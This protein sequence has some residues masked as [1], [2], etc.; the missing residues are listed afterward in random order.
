MWSAGRTSG[1]SRP[2]KLRLPVRGPSRQPVIDLCLRLFL[3]DYRPDHDQQPNAKDAGER[4]EQDQ[5]D[6]GGSHFVSF[7]ATTSVLLADFST[8][9]TDDVLGPLV[10]SM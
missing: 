4:E 8:V 7:S 6:G 9:V 1:V 5:Q 2:A 3:V 10:A